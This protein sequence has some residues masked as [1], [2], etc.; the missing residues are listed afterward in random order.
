MTVQ[1]D[2]LTQYFIGTLLT[3][4]FHEIDYHLRMER[5]SRG[6]SRIQERRWMLTSE[7]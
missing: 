4:L 7:C 1:A 5:I 2:T 6:E 3:R